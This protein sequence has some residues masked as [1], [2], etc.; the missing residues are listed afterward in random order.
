VYTYGEDWVLTEHRRFVWGGCGTGVSPVNGGWLLLLELDGLDDNA[1]V[2]K[3]TWGLDLAGQS[4][5][6]NS[7]ESAGGIGGLLALS[8]P[9]DPN[10]PND[11]YGDFV[12][13]YDANGN[14]GQLVD[15]THDP[16]DPN[17]AMAA[18]YEYDPYGNV[19][20]KD[21]YYADENPIRWSTKYWDGETGLGYWGYRYYDPR[22]GRWT[23]RDPIEE[24]ADYNLSRACANTPVAIYDALGLWG[25]GRTVQKSWYDD[26]IRHLT[27]GLQECD[28]DPRCIAVLVAEIK[29]F[30]Q[31]YAQIPL[32]HS[33]FVG[34]PEFDWNIEDND[35]TTSP[36][37]PRAT[38][39]HF[40]H[41]GEIYP[42]LLRAICACD[43]RGF[44]GGVH[45]GQDYYAHWSK[46]WRA[47]WG[48]VS[49]GHDPDNGSKYR[50]AWNNANNW[51]QKML[52]KW[53]KNCRRTAYWDWVPKCPD[54]P[55]AVRSMTG[56]DP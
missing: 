41:F 46:G 7:L 25:A 24:V 54:C 23:S 12:C 28:G 39:R 20:A 55:C 35:W 48:H 37:N 17:G 6:L 53:Y 8:D 29:R 32:G 31:A 56:V 22:T 42:D 14:V 21:G 47:P 44:E 50:T 52:A 40:R 15:L 43:K 3:Y 30:Q 18:K 10:D 27:I 51:T 13:L 38:R 2:R 11:L 5:A 45:Q 16:N 33:D 26:K 9:N 19:I 4:G 1:V 34:Y 49:A 36:W